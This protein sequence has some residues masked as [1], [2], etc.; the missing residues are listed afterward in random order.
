MKCSPCR[1]CSV[2]YRRSPERRM[3]LILTLLLGYWTAP[4][5]ACHWANIVIRN[6]TLSQTQRPIYEDENGDREG[7][8]P[9][10][11]TTGRFHLI[12]I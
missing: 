3:F 1:A 7:P 5:S 8:D 11:T 2:Q 12:L 4:S 9:N 6:E 10:T